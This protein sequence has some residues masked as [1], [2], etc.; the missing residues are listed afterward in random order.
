MGQKLSRREFLGRCSAYAAG[1][2]AVS[3]LSMAGLDRN[4]QGFS[5]SSKKM[6]KTKIQVVLA[7]PSSKE[8]CWPNIGYDFEANKAEFMKNL[9]QY[10]PDVEFLPVTAMK[11]EDAKRILQSGVEVD[12]TIVYLSGC[13][14]GSVTEEIAEAG[15]PTV[16][17]DNL[18]AGSGEF[19]T[20][21]AGVR[22]KGLP[23]AAVSSSEFKDVAQAVRALDTIKKLKDSTVLVVGG[24]PDNKIEGCFGTR[25]VGVEFPEINEAYNTAD[26]STA[27]KWADQW[28]KEAAKIIEPKK[29]DIVKSAILYVA[30]TD[31]MKRYNAQAIAVNCLGGFYGGHMPAYPCLG[32]M[33]LNNDG[34]VGA[35]EADQRSTITMLLMNYLVGRP[36]FISDPV[37][38]TAKNRIIYAHCVAPTKVFGPDG[39]SNPFHIR[40]HSEDR[41]GACDRSLMPLDEMT[42]T[43]EFDAGK[44]QVIFHQGKTV[45]NVDLDLACRNKL[46]VE[47]QGDV[48]KLLN[49]WDQWGWHRVTFYGD[50]KRQVFQ[51]AQLLQFEVVEEA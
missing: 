45:E 50:F 35:C 4:P 7:H 25:M 23:V 6:G 39:P 51:I 24:K 32:F 41:K 36:G 38:D 1:M 26:K 37:I 21:Y 15:K 44:K 46:A 31:L 5:N 13:L 17:V 10:C 43:I 49:Y 48:Y 8:P 11:N 12:G 22:R 28:M 20:S 3:S 14:W 27:Q 30:M 9:R 29:A 33:Q 47:V 18:F 2:T 19:L 40:S 34:F 42:T 16:L